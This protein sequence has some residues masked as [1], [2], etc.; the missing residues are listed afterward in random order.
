M[1]EIFARGG[2]QLILHF[3]SHSKESRLTK[4]GNKKSFLYRILH[5]EKKCRSR[6]STKTIL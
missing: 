6:V 3:C 4:C 1:R 2:N 5:S